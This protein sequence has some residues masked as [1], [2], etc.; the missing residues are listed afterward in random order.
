MLKRNPAL[1]LLAAALCFAAASSPASESGSRLV[2]KHEYFWD[3]NK[4]WNHTPAFELA[5]ALSRKW[6]LGWE[7]ELDVVTGASR[8]I[9]ADKVGQFG[10]RELDAVSG[11]SKIEVRHSEAPSMTYSHGGT[12]VTGGL[13][14]S[15]ENDYSSL[16]PSGSVS[17]DF[18]E[19]NTTLGLSYGEFFDDFKPTGAFAGQGGKK[20]IRTLGSSIAQSLTPLTLVG[21][22]ASYITS[23]CYLGHPY[24][25]PMDS[26][27]AFMLERVPDRKQAGAVAGQLVQGY[28]LAGL[29]GSVNLDFR[30]YQDDWGIKSNTLDVK[31]SQYFS[32]GAYFR[33]RGR[34]Y[35][36]NGA[37]FAKPF[38]TGAEDFRTADIRFFP[39]SSW[40]VGAKISTAFP[41]SWGE[42]GFLP[43]RWDLQFDYLI[44]DTRG[45]KTA[46]A[47][48]PR[49]KLYQLYGPDQEYL[50]GVI[51]AG[52][53]FNL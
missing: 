40:L 25:P 30:R 41:E 20:R 1:R 5:L 42:S 44:R 43:D 31:V 2:L 3:R 21:F 13:Y 32:E 26:S 15:R 27:G 23:W 45:D 47:A 17:M 18:F 36:Q 49:S 46:A 4:V 22:N 8:R 51:M 39:F 33:L 34:Y 11:A 28:H 19:R 7:Q 52:L 24:N 16:S 53:V 29:L 14:S 6:T 38:Y 35:K 37:A 12:T 10:D 48:E 50:Q 9:G